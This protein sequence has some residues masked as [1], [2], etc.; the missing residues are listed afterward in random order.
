MIKDKKTKK[1]QLCNTTHTNN[2]LTNDCNASDK[3]LMCSYLLDELVIVYKH[4]V[5]ASVFQLGQG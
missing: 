1:P 2:Y 4:M 3:R 5:D